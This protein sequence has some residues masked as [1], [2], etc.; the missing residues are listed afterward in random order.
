MSES[1]QPARIRPRQDKKLERLARAHPGATD[2]SEQVVSTTS[3]IAELF[4]SEYK[5]SSEW[6]EDPRPK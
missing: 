1:K 3:E 4:D 2:S 5:P 6:G